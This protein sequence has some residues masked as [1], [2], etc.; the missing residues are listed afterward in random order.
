MRAKGTKTAQGI[1]RQIIR[2]LQTVRE[3][4]RIH[5]RCDRIKR[6]NDMQS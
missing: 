6:N 4:L 1:N 5:S 2:M 3:T